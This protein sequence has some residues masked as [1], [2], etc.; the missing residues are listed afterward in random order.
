MGT[1]EEEGFRMVQQ[2]LY[3]WGVVEGKSM[4]Q[5][6]GVEDIPYHYFV[7]LRARNQLR[8]LLIQNDIIDVASVSIKSRGSSV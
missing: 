6:G 2:N 3:Y 7:V 5:I 8:A 4:R 1:G